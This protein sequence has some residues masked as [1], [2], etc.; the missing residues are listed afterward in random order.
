MTRGVAINEIVDW[1]DYDFDD[2]V[3]DVVLETGLRVVA[4]DPETEELTAVNDDDQ[5][6]YLTLW[7]IRH[8]GHTLTL[9]GGWW[10]DTCD[11]SYCDLA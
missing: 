2:D 5:P 10:C 6:R 1:I 4:Y 3:H 8:K 7:D 9:S 11:S